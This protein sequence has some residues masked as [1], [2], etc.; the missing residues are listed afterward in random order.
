MIPVKILVQSTSFENYK[1]QIEKQ[2]RLKLFLI[3]SLIAIEVPM[4]YFAYLEAS[5]RKIKDY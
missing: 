4:Q 3:I 5:T 1:S 2:R